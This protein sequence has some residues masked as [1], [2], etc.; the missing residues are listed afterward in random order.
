MKRKWPYWVKSPWQKFKWLWNDRWYEISQKIGGC[1]RCGWIIGVKAE[2]S[3]TR[4]HWDGKG[5]DPN[6]DIRLCRHCAQ[7]HHQHWDATW[8]EYYSGLL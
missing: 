3:R 1:V 6:R 5:L 4:Y 7:E 2:S 8:D